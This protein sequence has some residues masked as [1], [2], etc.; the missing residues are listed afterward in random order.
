M[1]DILSVK[2]ELEMLECSFERNFDL[3][4]FEYFVAVTKS[5]DW[6]PNEPYITDGT[7]TP[8]SDSCSTGFYSRVVEPVP[9]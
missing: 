7:F 1:D 5:T 2:S 3:G 4:K 9:Q 8:L 6:R